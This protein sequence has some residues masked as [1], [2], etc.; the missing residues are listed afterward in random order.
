M[1]EFYERNLAMLLFAVGKDLDFKGV[2]WRKLGHLH[3]GPADLDA[4]WK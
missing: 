3:C 2:Q 4:P 1:G